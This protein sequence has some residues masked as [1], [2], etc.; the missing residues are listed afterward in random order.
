MAVP[1]VNYYDDTEPPPCVYSEKRIPNAG[2]P[3]NLDADFLS[4][5]DCEDDCLVSHFE[6][7]R[8]RSHVLYIL[9]TAFVFPHRTKPVASAPD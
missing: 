2:V 1:C 3:L 5:C 7:G 9:K 4:C 8:S 6:G